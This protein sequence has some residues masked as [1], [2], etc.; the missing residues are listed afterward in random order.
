MDEHAVI[1]ALNANSIK[2]GTSFVGLRHSFT[3]MLHNEDITWNIVQ[4]PKFRCNDH[5]SLFNF[6][7]Q[8][9]LRLGHTTGV[10]GTYMLCK[11]S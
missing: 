4:I 7:N 9:K 6:E 5:L 11:P 1:F 2:L 8:Q 10:E 3:G